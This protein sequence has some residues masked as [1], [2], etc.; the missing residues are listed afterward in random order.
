MLEA[1]ASAAA[2]EVRSEFG[3]STCEKG[4]SKWLYSQVGFGNESHV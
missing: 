2:T 4:K 3:E 1:L